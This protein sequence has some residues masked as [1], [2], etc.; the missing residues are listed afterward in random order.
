[1]SRDVLLARQ[2]TVSP[3]RELPAATTAY[4][5]MHAL[6]LNNEWTPGFQV[7]EVEAAELFA[8]SRTPVRE[9]FMLLE[10]DGLVEVVPRRGLRVLPVSPDDMREIYQV[11]TSLEAT[12]AELVASARPA[13]AELVSLDEATS[14]MAAALE[15]DD[16]T[17]WAEADERFHSE[18]LVLCGNG[19]LAAVVTNCWGRMHR[20]RMITLRMRPK[21]VRSTQE[22]RALV[23][24]LRRGDPQAAGALH[25][26]HRQLAGEEL[27]ALLERFGLK[28]L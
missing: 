10:R 24:A 28:T 21:P 18:L 26:A 15:A 17:A 20:A 12:A 5:A 23:E 16:L 3:T 25:R 8:M 27:V 14:A 7:T 19:T 11:V 1:M 22:H 4:R 6:I 9:A 2:A 13:Q